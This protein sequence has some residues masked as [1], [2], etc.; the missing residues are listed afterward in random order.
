[1]PD[2]LPRQVEIAVAGGSI[3]GL[4]A[5]TALLAA[6]F[7]VH[8]FERSPGRLT[9]RGAGI[10]VQPDLLGLL[11]MV[12]APP[13]AM[14]GCTVRRTLLG[15]SGRVE[16]MRM[17]Q[18]FTSW[19][20][21]YTALRA[22]FPND[23]YHSGAALELLDV[24]ADG[25]RAQIDGDAITANLLV[26]ADG[27]RSA[28]RAHYAPGTV[29]HYAGYVA[30]RGVVDEAA[31]PSDLAGVFDDAFTFCQVASG[32]HALCYLIPGV[33]LATEKGGRRL[34][35]VWYVP[36][37]EGPALDAVMTDRQDRRRDAAMPEGMVNVEALADLHRR[38]ERLDPN[39]AALVRATPEPFIQA[40][41]DMAPPSMVYG[42]V[43]LLGDAAFVV[44]P[45]TAAASAKAA[46]DATAL[47]AALRSHAPDID[48]G[49]VAW[50]RQRLPAGRALLDY[51]VRLGSRST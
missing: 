18:W 31:V 4:S 32:G 13:L 15:T 11:A 26:A 30:W 50:E 48:A 51:G 12:G 41:L 17:P 2:A 34:N 20:A 36:V 3:G 19:E 46:A 33:G 49:L 45:H 21:I 40:I 8:V 39:F 25:V 28:L 47:A 38:T 44:R 35:W 43:C 23:R 24:T 5:G 1:M 7:D 16:E 37:A 22:A 27:L 9:S 42:R 29:S 10:V 14:T 6:G